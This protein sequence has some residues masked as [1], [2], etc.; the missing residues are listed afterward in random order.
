MSN[1][2]LEQI[3]NIKTVY[4]ASQNDD[5]VIIVGAG[6]SQNSGLPG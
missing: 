6:I 5:L 2:T 3:E 4:E 1:F